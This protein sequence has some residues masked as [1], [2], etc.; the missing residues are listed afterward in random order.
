VMEFQFHQVDVGEPRHRQGSNHPYG[1]GYS[2][3]QSMPCVRCADEV[4][5]QM[6]VEPNQVPPD[7]HTHWADWAF[8]LTSQKALGA[9]RQLGIDA[10]AVRDGRSLAGD[11]YFRA[12][13][14]VEDAHHPE[15]GVFPVPGFFP[16]MSR[17]P[18]VERFNAASVGEHNDWVYRD[19]LGLSDDDYRGLARDG[20]I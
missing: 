9:L 2:L 17:G 13:A 14:D 3:G 19:F 16:K 10:V 12:R 4:W 20:V 5:V 1:W 7:M 8:S 18:E 11:R 15:L 6:C